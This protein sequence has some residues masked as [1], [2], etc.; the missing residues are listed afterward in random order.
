MCMEDVRMGRAVSSVMLSININNITSTLVLDNDPMRTVIV[1]SASN[2]NDIMLRTDDNTVSGGL[3]I[4]TASPAITLTV[5][6]HG[7]IVTK[8]WYAFST[9]GAPTINII[10]GSLEKK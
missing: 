3:Y 2:A 10:V 7:H 6:E 4:P 1:F 9:T 5:A 8:A